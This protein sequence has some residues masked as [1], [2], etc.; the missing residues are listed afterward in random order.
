MSWT[1]IEE[2]LV[3]SEDGT[4][5]L[6]TLNGEYRQYTLGAEVNE[7][8]VIS[9]ALYEDG[10]VVLHGGL[11]FVH[12]R[13]WEGGRAVPFGVQGERE[14]RR[15]V[16]RF[17]ATDRSFHRSSA[18]P[19]PPHCWTVVP[20]GR[21]ISGHVEVLAAVGE[22]VLTIDELETVDQVKFS[23]W[24]CCSNQSQ[25]YFTFQLPQHLSRGPF[26]HIKSSPNGK[27]LALITTSSSLWVVSSDFS[28]NL[29]EV[30]V[31]S[32][33]LTTGSPTG[34]VIETVEWCGDHAV[35]LTWKGGK[36]AVVGPRSECLR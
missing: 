13:G 35:V 28:R 3:L 11:G 19:S 14:N 24:A 18:L 23:P 10:L 26:T 2:L 5:R 27:F 4:Y 32:L 7:L 25:A 20:P 29:S 30:D 6:Y 1:S 22:T 17:L 16:E 36:V 21:S 31:N 12:V 8:G 15:D 34:D 9:A 33:Q